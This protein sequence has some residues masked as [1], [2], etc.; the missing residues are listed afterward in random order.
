MMNTRLLAWGGFAAALLLLSQAGLTPDRSDDLRVALLP[1]CPVAGGSVESGA[2]AAAAAVA[3]GETLALPLVKAAAQAAQKA[4]AGHASPALVGSAAGHYFVSNGAGKVQVNG[5]WGCL[6]VAV[7]DL[8][9]RSAPEAAA[10]AGSAK[11]AW[12]GYRVYLEAE[13]VTAPDGRAFQL[14]PR[15]L[16]FKSA[17]ESALLGSKAR[18]LAFQVALTSPGQGQPFATTTL[19]FRSLLPSPAGWGLRE[20][21]AP[22]AKSSGWLPAPAVDEAARRTL[23]QEAAA[24][25]RGPARRDAAEPTARK[26]GPTTVTV[27]LVETREGSLLAGFVADTL[28]S[29]VPS[30]ASPAPSP[31]P[32]GAP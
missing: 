25:A 18:D 31:G 27:S 21:G 13:I 17:A 24:R 9:A 28:A 14:L 7:V 1:I 12:D 23:A 29:V 2:G 16:R 4:A 22:P 20:L 3:L 30:L 8:R 11:D 15:T 10:A 26:L 19:D 6:Q 5:L 32:K